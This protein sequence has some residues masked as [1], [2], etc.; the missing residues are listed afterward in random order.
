MKS[1]EGLVELLLWAQGT[2]LTYLSVGTG[3]RSLGANSS[4]PD[5]EE[6]SWSPSSRKMGILFPPL[7]HTP[8]GVLLR[9]ANQVLLKVDC[10]RYVQQ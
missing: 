3:R 5:E 1:W 9:W 7:T 8:M 6:D 2:G 4:T 10:C